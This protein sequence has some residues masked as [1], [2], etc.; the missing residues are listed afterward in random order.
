MES[1]TSGKKQTRATA[2]GRWPGKPVGL[3]AVRLAARKGRPGQCTRDSR[4][5]RAARARRS[6]R[7]PHTHSLSLP[8][9]RKA[10]LN[11]QRLDT[12]LDIHPTI[13]CIDFIEYTSNPA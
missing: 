12:V 8:R 10:E 2:G 5:Q 4:Q 6:L 1:V 3:L 7:H 13:R 9:S 11:K